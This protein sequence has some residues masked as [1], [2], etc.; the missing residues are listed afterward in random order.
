MRNDELWF[1]HAQT[2]DRST[3]QSTEVS[4]QGPD[5]G[6]VK[7]C[8]ELGHFTFDASFDDFSNSGI[9]FLQVVEARPFTAA[10]VLSMAMRAI[11]LKQA[12]APLGFCLQA[13]LG[14]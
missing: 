12:V 13:R 7:F 9:G 5:V 1:T 4:D 10:G 11:M 2:G 3:F 6:I 8:A 14:G